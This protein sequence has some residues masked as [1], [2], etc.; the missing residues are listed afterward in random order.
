MKNH[1]KLALI[2]GAYGGIGSAIC[3]QL[4]KEGYS[5]IL[6]GR[7]KEKLSE[8]ANSLKS[9][10]PSQEFFAQTANSTEAESMRHAAESVL[11]KF[12]QI[13]VLINTVGIVP[14]GSIREVDEAAWSNGIQ[15]SLMS[16]VRLVKYFSEALIKQGNGSIILI[17]GVLSVQPEPGFI[18][19][20]VVTGAIR[21]LIKAL[22]RDFAQF[23]IR[24]NGI[25]PGATHTPLWSKITQELGQKN[26]IKAQAITDNVISIN[27]LKK[28]AEPDDIANAVSFLC[29]EQAQYING[30]TINIDGGQTTAA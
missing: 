26:Q 9:I 30:V 18:I 14:I 12:K 15:T 20:S 23:N 5:L 16:A 24:V 17:N 22:S 6:L 4:A 13:D 10:H 25:N 8:L 27:P 1:K 7:N 29:S 21:N 11:Q 2:N 19:S 28:M 3:K